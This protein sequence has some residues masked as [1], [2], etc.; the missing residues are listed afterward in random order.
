MRGNGPNAYNGWP[1]SPRM[2][3]LRDTW[4]AAEEKPTQ[5]A[6]ARQMQEVL[7]DEVPYLPLGSYFQP[8]AYKANLVDMPKGLVQFTGVKRV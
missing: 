4:L 2:E 1:A 8:V 3:T 7:M 6:I 5:L